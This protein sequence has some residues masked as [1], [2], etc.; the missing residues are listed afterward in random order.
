MHGPE[1][2]CAETCPRSRSATGIRLPAIE[3]PTATYTGWGLRAEG[4]AGPDLCDH[5]GQQIDFAR[6]RAERLESGDPRP[7]LEQRYPDHE[8]YV[9][10]VAVAARS[11]ARQRL[12]LAED[13]ERII[14]ESEATVF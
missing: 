13:V 7:S 2:Y 11:L 3:V 9:R 1:P 12:L 10:A 5:Y 4:F 6:T 14:E 8:T